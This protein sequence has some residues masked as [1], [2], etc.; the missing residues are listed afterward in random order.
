MKEK[1][2]VNKTSDGKQFYSYLD[3]NKLS[4]EIY[5]N[6]RIPKKE[7][8]RW[9]LGVRGIKQME[10]DVFKKNN[11]E[12]KE[13]YSQDWTA[14]NQAQQKEKVLLMNILNELLDYIPF[15]KRKGVGR[16]PLSIK[17]KIFH[18]V[19]QSYN[20]KSSRRCV[21]DLEIAKRLG[22]LEKAPHFNSV[23]KSLRDPSITNYLNHL[24]EVSGLPLKN[25]ESDFAIDSSGFSTSQFDRWLD[26]RAEPNSMKRRFKKCHLTCG[27]KTNIITAV[28]I[29]KARASD[30][31]EFPDLVKK[32]NKLYDIRE[33]SADK[34]YLSKKHFLLV[35]Q[36][37][38]IAY[39]PFKKNTTGKRGSTKL[40]GDMYRYFLN[41]QEEYMQHYHKRSNSETV[42]HMLK[43]KFSK[44]LRS[45][46]ESGQTNEIL[47]KCLCH[48]LCVL[49]QESF[50]L[51]IELD[52]KKCAEIPIAHIYR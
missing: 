14:Y 41:H 3:L 28:N 32:T 50:E 24:I 40:W 44:H 31:N 52:F 10:I 35:S 4:K 5:E 34:A 20:L 49:I 9:K 30:S 7:M 21:S 1:I 45:K 16:K 51:G 29:T 2:N 42:F 13:T 25:V 33:I 6:M 8:K 27:V 15:P 47:A 22:Y 46:D 19:L 17:D 48:N 12:K 18:I 23:L 26:V 11:G 43:T 36:I 39:I 37:G 38:G